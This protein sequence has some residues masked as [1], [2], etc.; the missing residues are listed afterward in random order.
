MKKLVLFNIFV[1]VLSICFLTGNAMAGMTGKE[2]A[3][4]VYDRDIGKDS[5]A[6]CYMKLI[7]KNGHERARDFTIRARKD[8][9]GLLRQITRFFSPADIRGTGFLSIE[10][11]DDKTDQFLFLPALHRTH[12]IVSSGRGKSFVNTDFTYEDMDRRPVKSDEHKI[13]GEAVKGNTDCYIL[14][15]N[16]KKETNSQYSLIKSWIAK[17]SYVPIYTELYNKK[18]KLEKIYQAADL[19]KVEGVWTVMEAAMENLNKKTKTIIKINK[20]KYNLS[21][22]PKLF[23]NR[24]L[25]KGI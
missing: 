23:T 15:S 1:A 16:P 7:S 2:L 5:S 13:I 6:E 8:K 3:Q 9:D 12:R 14:E 24:Y 18:G 10:R 21:L 11:E 22:H 25:E 20:I 19:K 4:L 17:N